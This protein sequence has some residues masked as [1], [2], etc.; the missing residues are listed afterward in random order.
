M[1]DEPSLIQHV[2]M[3]KECTERN[4]GGTVIG[5]KKIYCLKYADDVEVA[6]DTEEGLREMIVNLVKYTK[7]NDLN[8]KKSKIICFRKRGRRQKKRNW[9][10]K[11]EK[12]EV[13]TIK[14]LGYRLNAKNEHIKENRKKKSKELYTPHGVQ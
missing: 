9:F 7:K 6:S 10:M 12:I 1:L 14:Y 13:E 5:N 8:C 2:Y 11:G 4:L 3:K